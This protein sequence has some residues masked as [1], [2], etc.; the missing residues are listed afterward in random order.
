MMKLNTVK[1]NL[2]F[3]NSLSNI[4]TRRMLLVGQSNKGTDKNN[5]IIITSIYSPTKAVSEFSKMKDWQL[6]VVADQKTPDGWQYDNVLFFSVSDQTSSGYHL[7]D[8]LPWNH[9]C[10]KMMGYILAMRAGATIIVD[11]DDDNISNPG[12]NV[13]PFAGNYQVADQDMGFLNI[14]QMF[15]DNMIWPRGFPLDQI[16]KSVTNDIPPF[17]KSY[18]NVGIWQ[19]LADGDPDVDAIYRLTN[20]K[21]CFFDNKEPIVLGRGTLCPFNSQN[22]AFTK[23]A[24]PLLYLPATV[25]FRFTDILRGYIAQP[26]LWTKELHLGFT[27]A[28]VVQERNP[29]DFLKDFESEI[30]CYLYAEK[31][32]SIVNKAIHTGNTVE[33]N[34]YNA[35]LALINAGIVHQD[36][37]RVL[38]A[39]L[40]DIN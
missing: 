11:T 27:D 38:D 16:H 20:N 33:D 28:T 36:E 7:A 8:V 30:P 22:T 24:F 2:L 29:H 13:L 10:R 23:E 17:G 40:K 26:I 1:H 21:P 12:W 32:I 6:I 31:I 37:I 14:Y 15:T 35:Y 5:F 4:T 39:W 3:I 34:L 19:G 9:Y 25:T 18:V